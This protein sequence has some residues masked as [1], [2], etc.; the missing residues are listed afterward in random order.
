MKGL[1]KIINK[2]NTLLVFIVKITNNIFSKI[3]PAPT[4]IWFKKITTQIQENHK[5]TKKTS[6]QIEQLKKI[7]DKIE[8]ILKKIVNGISV[9]IDKIQRIDFKK[10][11][12]Q[13]IILLILAIF[14]P[15]FLRLKVWILTLKPATMIGAVVISSI[16]GIASVQIYTN[17]KQIK[18]KADAEKEKE[19]IVVDL[20][21]R[22]SKYYKEDERQIL[23]SNIVLPVYIESVSS[24]KSLTIDFILVMSNRYLKA[25]FSDNEHLIKN[26]LSYTIEPIIPTF[27]LTNEGKTILKDKIKKE[28]NTLIFDLNIAGEIEKIYF[29]NIIGG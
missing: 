18:E 16:G 22:R 13:K 24:I 1:E 10:V 11:S 19:Q 8:I 27:P 2:I 14:A 26:K 15:V 12:P 25:Y 29:Q 23:V 20:S 28:L 3:V 21:Q 9:V 4:K 5:S 7:L 17:A 6:K